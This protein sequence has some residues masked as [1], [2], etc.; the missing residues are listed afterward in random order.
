MS[1]GNSGNNKLKTNMSKGNSGNNKEEGFY[2]G[3]DLFPL[4]SAKSPEKKSP[5]SRLPA[6]EQKEMSIED[7]L[8]GL[9]S[10][11]SSRVLGVIKYI[12][13]HMRKE[14]EINKIK[15]K[16]VGKFSEL[17]G[18]NFIIGE[19]HQHT[20]PKKFLIQNMSLLKD[21]GFNT[22]FLEHLCT[23]E[24][25]GPLNDLYN[26]P[27]QQLPEKFKNYLIGQDK[28][29]DHGH[30]A[31]Y[32]FLKL[33]ESAID[34]GVKIIALEANMAIYKGELDL[35][36]L[37]IREPH[38]K[39]GTKRTGRLNIIELPC[40][41]G[42]PRTAL[43][44][45]IAAHRIKEYAQN[46]PGKKWFS[47]VGEGHVNTRNDMPGI[48]D[49]INSAGIVC[50]D[51]NI[52]D[53]KNSHS[54]F[55]LKEQDDFSKTKGE[56]HKEEILSSIHLSVGKDVDLSM[57]SLLEKAGDSKD[58]TEA[59]GFAHSSSSQPAA[60]YPESEDC[61]SSPSSSVETGSNSLPKRKIGSESG[62]CSPLKKPRTEGKN[63]ETHTNSHVWTTNK[64]K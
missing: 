60:T 2:V 42:P 45:Y 32:G 35:G 51:I 15:N 33:V 56:G 50:G 54:E 43:L 57:V 31:E 61:D 11:N 28:G 26:S 38:R 30:N 64:C 63:E 13:T 40:K 52:S 1:K 16:D 44:N 37:D 8:G 59:K 4:E 23:R 25:Q 20:S 3:G 18:N 27:A 10:Q 17:L 21:R 7:V 14:E 53:I 6:A 58:N 9:N 36:L 49:L 29:F 19:T 48:A 46:N 55:S 62:N 34:N 22:L 39:A 12:K 5:G 47:L 24:H 41:A